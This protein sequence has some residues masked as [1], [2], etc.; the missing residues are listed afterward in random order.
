MSYSYRD[1]KTVQSHR[2][3]KYDV[4]NG[5]IAVTSHVMAFF[6][7]IVVVVT[8]VAVIVVEIIQFSP[9]Q[10]SL[11]IPFKMKYIVFLTSC[12]LDFRYHFPQ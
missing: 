5:Q 6:I 3:S 2:T 10:F 4:A 9:V 8:I 7:I 1:P 11:F 12:Q